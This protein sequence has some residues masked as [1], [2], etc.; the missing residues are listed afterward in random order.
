M[1]SGLTRR[2][3]SR[4]STFIGDVALLTGLRST[5]SL[6]NADDLDRQRR[7]QQDRIHH[8]PNA[9]SH[10]T[11]P[12]ANSSSS[13]FRSWQAAQ[14]VDIQHVTQQAIVHELTQ[15]QMRLI[16][17]RR[18]FALRNESSYFDICVGGCNFFSSWSRFRSQI[19]SALPSPPGKTTMATTATT[20][21]PSLRIWMPHRARDVTW[22]P[23]GR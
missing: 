15:Q 6:K 3:R 18:Q 7:V 14:N 12:I 20:E 11:K 17:V 8:L 10:S 19:S 4:A 5:T 23:A 16:R 1:R 2:R 13:S 9:R 21:S 22:M